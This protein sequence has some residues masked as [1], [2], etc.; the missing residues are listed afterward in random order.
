MLDVAVGGDIVQDLAHVVFIRSKNPDSTRPTVI[1]IFSMA[2]S[3]WLR[4]TMGQNNFVLDTTSLDFFPRRGWPSP[5]TLFFTPLRMDDLNRLDFSKRRNENHFRF[6]TGGSS[7]LDWTHNKRNG[8]RE[9]HL[10]GGF[11]Y[12]ISRSNPSIPIPTW[13]EEKDIENSVFPPR[14]C[15]AA[16]TEQ[17]LN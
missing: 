5:S 10:G 7:R 8:K 9:T 3:F 1:L 17:R 11:C 15:L 6:Q 14:T 16:R 4:P 13:K 2:A 12:V